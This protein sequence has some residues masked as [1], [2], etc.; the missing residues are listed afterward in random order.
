MT[1][2]SQSQHTCQL[3]ALVLL[4]ACAAMVGAAQAQEPVAQPSNVQI[5]GL[6]DAYIGSMRRSDQTGRTSVLNSNGMTTAYWG[7]RGTEDLGGG[8]KASVRT[9]KLLPL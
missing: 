1:E 5:Y 2:P 9:G 4:S 8:L 3:Q 6:V 7:V